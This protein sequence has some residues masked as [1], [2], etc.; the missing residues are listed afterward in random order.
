MIVCRELT[1]AADWDALFPLIR[2]LNGDM[3]RADYDR[4][5]FTMRGL[6]Y[7]CA[8]AFEGEQMV[9]ALG[10]WVGYRFFC[11]KYLDLDN[12][13][14]DAGRRS[15]GIGTQLLTWVE[16]EGKRLECDIVVLDTYV[17]NAASHRLYFREDYA[18]LGY[19]FVKRL[20]LGGKP[21]K[22]PALMIP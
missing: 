15:Q 4:T 21:L 16:N 2:Q 9:G 10:F 6:G 17:G 14:I 12:F 5:L 20:T 22:S 18:I 13:V 7:R 8:G 3:E 1:G 11:G 19:H